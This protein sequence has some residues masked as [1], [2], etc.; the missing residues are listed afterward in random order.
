MFMNLTITALRT[1]HSRAP[2]GSLIMSKEPLKEIIE[3]LV[4]HNRIAKFMRVDFCQ[5]DLNYLF[6]DCAIVFEEI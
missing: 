4:F 6:K 1:E 5:R 2:E 3:S